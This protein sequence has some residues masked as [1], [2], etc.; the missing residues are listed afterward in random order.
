[1]LKDSETSGHW[2]CPFCGCV[3]EFDADMPKDNKVECSECGDKAE[4]HHH[5]ATW[6]DFWVYCQSL[7]NI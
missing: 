2:K 7:K 5:V 6:K 3:E 4:P 1:M